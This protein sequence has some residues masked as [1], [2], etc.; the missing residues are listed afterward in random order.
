MDAFKN[1]ER[2][3]GLRQVRPDWRGATRG[4]ADRVLRADAPRASGV[5]SHAGDDPFRE[6]LKMVNSN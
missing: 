3:M 6:E 5:S 4:R 2:R 1:R